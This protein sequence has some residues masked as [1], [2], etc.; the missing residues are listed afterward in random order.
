MKK[1]KKLFNIEEY[2]KNNGSDF[3]YILYNGHI[4][5]YN[6]IKNKSVKEMIDNLIIDSNNI[7]KF[8]IGSK[9][10]SKQYLTL[11]VVTYHSKRFYR[12]TYNKEHF[13][14]TQYLNYSRYFDKRKP[15]GTLE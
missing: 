5:E 1:A 12:M 7:Y 3:L 13:K 6:N 9:Y 2:V 15:D 4:G 11:L 14:P 10:K 8:E